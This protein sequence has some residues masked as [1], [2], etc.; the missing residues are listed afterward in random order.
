MAFTYPLRELLKSFV[1]ES[2]Q[3]DQA[4]Q[5]TVDIVQ[6]RLH[7]SHQGLHERLDLVGVVV[8]KRVLRLNTRGVHCMC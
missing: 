2:S 8:F 5:G 1:P 7:N 3:H 6:G 4:T